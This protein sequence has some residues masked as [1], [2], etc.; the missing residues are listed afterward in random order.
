MHF[1]I[2]V[3]VLI[4][5]AFYHRTEWGT[6]STH[7]HSDLRTVSQR[8]LT[9]SLCS[10]PWPQISPA[11]GR[12]PPAPPPRYSCYQSE[13]CCLA[14]ITQAAWCTD[15]AS[16]FISRGSE[17]DDSEART[18]LAGCKVRLLLAMPVR[19]SGG[20]SP[21]GVSGSGDDALL[22]GSSPPC[23]AGTIKDGSRSRPQS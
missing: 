23:N 16:R 8:R 6:N 10:P 7:L 5:M 15:E 1:F 11:E 18:C 22:R 19:S 3:C 13:A 14:R 2:R 17:R 4:T 20:R 21:M 12:H 9:V